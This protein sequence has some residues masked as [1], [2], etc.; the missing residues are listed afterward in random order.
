MP[1][2]AAD[3]PRP[4][5]LRLFRI[6]VKVD[7]ADSGPEKSNRPPASAAPRTRIDRPENCCE[8][9]RNGKLVAVRYRVISHDGEAGMTVT[10]TFRMEPE[11]PPGI[12]EGWFYDHDLPCP[13]CH[14]NLRM[15]RTPRCPECDNAYP[16]QLLLNLSCARCG[17]SLTRESGERCPECDLELDWAALIDG[18]NPRSLR[19]YEYAPNPV[20][21]ALVTFWQALSPG[22]FWKRQVLEM[23]PNT[24]RLRSM[25]SAIVLFYAFV[26][27]LTILL[28]VL[29]KWSNLTSRLISTADIAATLIAVLL[30]LTTFVMLPCF[31][32]T[33][34]LCRLRRDQLL[35]VAAYG[36]AGIFWSTL[37]CFGFLCAAA[38]YNLY[39]SLWSV[40]QNPIFISTRIA[41]ID[42]YRASFYGINAW[43]VRFSAY[44]RWLYTFFQTVWWW[45]FLWLALRRFLRL[46]LRNALALF[47]STQIIGLLIMEILNLWLV[48]LSR[49]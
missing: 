9:L 20:R 24:Q 44:S 15:L 34:K 35:R 29:F 11:L 38:I 48:I 14:Y 37:L 10:A 30:P 3:V 46:N 42:V 12:P 28:R 39:I 31:G 22:R 40:N 5:R 45:P 13:N 43:S 41:A 1:H 17:A 47:V 25:L 23:A 33:L 26:C 8:G 32:P 18:V 21:A 27:G 7:R 2:A 19:N 16:W 49:Y 4:K 36:T 6:I